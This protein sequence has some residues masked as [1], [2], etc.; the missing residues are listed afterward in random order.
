MLES[1]SQE[2]PETPK[3]H[4][5]QQRQDGQRYHRTSSPTTMTPSPPVTSNIAIPNNDAE[6]SPCYH[7]V[8]DSNCHIQDHT[9]TSSHR[10]QRHTSKTAPLPQRP[11]TVT[12]PIPN[13]DAEDSPCYNH[14]LDSNCHI[15]D[16]DPTL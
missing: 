16:N 14:D 9:M 15:Q 7:H 4:L 3:P 12:S 5:L 8:L 1:W 10:Q 2:H 11:Q 13:N 6:D